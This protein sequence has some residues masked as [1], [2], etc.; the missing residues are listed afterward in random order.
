M[1]NL[2]LKEQKSGRKRLKKIL[3]RKKEEK[4]KKVEEEA[5]QL[6]DCKNIERKNN[7]CIRNRLIS[8]LISIQ[9]L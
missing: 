3:Q 9:F 4:N 1:K 2:I 7:G 6:E 8:Y 5:T